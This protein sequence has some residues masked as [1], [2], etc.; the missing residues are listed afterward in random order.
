MCLVEDAVGSNISQRGDGWI[1]IYHPY[2]VRENIFPTSISPHK[3]YLWSSLSTDVI[4]DHNGKFLDDGRMDIF[5]D[6]NV[7]FDRSFAEEGM[8]STVNRIAKIPS[9]QNT[10]NR[11]SILDSTTCSS[12][13]YCS[14]CFS[15]IYIYG[16]PNL[17]YISSTW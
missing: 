9:N 8:S 3:L 16:Q 6:L 4:L 17:L 10:Q 2:R 12:V 7:W 1:I 14:L 11:K 15:H 13:P 5:K